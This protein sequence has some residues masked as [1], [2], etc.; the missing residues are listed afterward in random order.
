MKIAANRDHAYH[1]SQLGSLFS[2]CALALGAV[3]DYRDDIRDTAVTEIQQ[4]LEWG[5][6]LAG[7]VCEEAERLTSG[8]AS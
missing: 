7:N 4:V 8:G 6:V 5:A 2:V 3:D 1:V